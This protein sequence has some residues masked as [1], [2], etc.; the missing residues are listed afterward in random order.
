LVS[1]FAQKLGIKLFAARGKVEIEAQDDEMRLVADGAVKVTSARGRVV[2]E[3][4]EEILLK[5]R[6]SYLRMSATGIEE[7]TRGERTIHSAGVLRQGP[8][9]LGHEMNTWKH[10]NFGEQ[11]VLRRMFDDKPMAHRQFKVIRADGSVITGVT[12]AEGRT[13]L[14]K[15]LFTEGVQLI[16]SPE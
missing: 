16:M 8:T 10:A 12:D 1:L 5:C 4:K 13:G 6:G 15:S 9:S 7:G 2:I 3:A 11:F 14:Q